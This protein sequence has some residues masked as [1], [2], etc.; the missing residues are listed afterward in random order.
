[1]KLHLINLVLDLESRAIVSGIY[2]AG[3]TLSFHL[4]CSLPSI[5]QVIHLPVLFSRLFA[6]SFNK[7]TVFCA[8]VSDTSRYILRGNGAT[9]LGRV[10]ICPHGDYETSVLEFP[11]PS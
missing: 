9:Q 5:Y 1:M 6:H 10:K 11:H 3:H 4:H 7:A 8:Y 2:S